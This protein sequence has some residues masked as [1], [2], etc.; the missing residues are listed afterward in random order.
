VRD[1]PIRQLVIYKLKDFGCI[2]LWELNPEVLGS[3][4]L[5]ASEIWER[6]ITLAEGLHVWEKQAMHLLNY[7][8]ALALLLRKNMENLSHG[9]VPQPRS[10]TYTSPDQAGIYTNILGCM[11]SLTGHIHTVYGSLHLLNMYTYTL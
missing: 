6:E 3:L 8:L 5:I 7:I 10:P 9:L 2:T 4:W 11:T 1:Y